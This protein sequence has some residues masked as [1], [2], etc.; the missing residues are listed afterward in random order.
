MAD[1]IAA[2]QTALIAKYRGDAPLQ[3]LMTGGS[4]PEWNIYDQGGAGEITPAFPYVYVHPIT[5]QTGTASTLDSDAMDVFV[6]VSVFTK[7]LGFAQA[8]AI[9]SRIYALTHR[10]TPGSLFI[11]GFTNVQTMFNNRQELEE[12][13]D[14]TIQHIAD[15]YKILTQG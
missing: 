12:I 4:S 11:S 13:T 1:P 10:P 8:R 14:G 3:G 15:R 7:A 9:A 5:S 2:I 6:Q